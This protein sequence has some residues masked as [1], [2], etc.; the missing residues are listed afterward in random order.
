MELEINNIEDS[1]ENENDLENLGEIK[2][3]GTFRGLPLFYLE[4]EKE[5]NSF[6]RGFK[7]FRFWKQH[8]K[9]EKIRQWA[10]KN[11]YKNFYVSYNNLYIKINR[12]RIR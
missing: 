9:S 10:N 8:T 6:F 3:D 5:F 4:S 7:T 11:P 2:P 12:E 1:K